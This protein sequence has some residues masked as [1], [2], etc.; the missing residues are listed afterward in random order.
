MK[1][2]VYIETSIVSYLTARLSR[3]LIVAGHRQITHEWWA[4]HRDKFELF[5]SQTVLEEATAGDPEAVQQRLSA[6]ENLPLLEITEEAVALAKDL[7][8]PGPLP[9]KAEVDALHIAIAVTNKVDY[10]LTWNCKHL[11]NAALRSRIER[12]CRL[13]GY[14]PVVICTPEELLED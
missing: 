9:E 13:Q 11:A 12:V 8:H 4:N 6:I 1:W 5:V 2:R 7:V 10:L 3:D 14:D